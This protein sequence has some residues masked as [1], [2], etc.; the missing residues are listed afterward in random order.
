P[1]AGGGGGGCIPSCTS[2]LKVII[3]SSQVVDCHQDW[4]GRCETLQ[5][6]FQ[7]ISLETV[8]SENRCLFLEANLDKFADHI[9]AHLP[10]DSPINLSAHGCMPFTV[11]IKGGAAVATIRGCDAPA[12]LREVTK[13]M[14][15]QRT[16]DDKDAEPE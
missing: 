12:I 9:Q 13:H 8:D 14:P 1:K 7:R 2:L 4:C 3:V 6:T 16:S 15:P 11:L 10:K 5:P